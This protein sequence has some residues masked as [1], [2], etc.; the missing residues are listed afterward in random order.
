MSFPKSNV[1]GNFSNYASGKYFGTLAFLEETVGNR[2][3]YYAKQ[4]LNFFEY[5]EV[6]ILVEK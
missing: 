4:K 3:I 6:R 5:V 2:D 1:K